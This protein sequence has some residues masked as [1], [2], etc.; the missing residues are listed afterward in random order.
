MVWVPALHFPNFVP[1]GLSLSELRVFRCYLRSMLHTHVVA[2]EAMDA[3]GIYSFSLEVKVFV[4][5]TVTVMSN[6]FN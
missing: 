6:Y 5:V 1:E 4:V 2:M 3:T